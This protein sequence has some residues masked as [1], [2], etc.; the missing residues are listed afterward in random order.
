MYEWRAGPPIGVGCDLSRVVFEALA[1]LLYGLLVLSFLHQGVAFFFQDLAFL[2]V[3]V[4]GSWQEEKQGEECDGE[5]REDGFTSESI[6][7]SCSWLW[8]HAQKKPGY[9][10]KPENVFTCSWTS[11][12]KIW[13]RLVFHLVQFF[14][15]G[16]PWY[17]FHVN[18]AKNDALI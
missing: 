9:W 6:F 3:F 2:H 10:E 12:T 7:K 18:R 17:Q 8:L 5:D 14:K 16:F 13:N 1:V 4:T 11:P 15:N